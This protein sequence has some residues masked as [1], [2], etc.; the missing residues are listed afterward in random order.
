VDPDRAGV[1]TKVRVYDAE[2][3]TYLGTKQRRS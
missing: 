3:G 2:R 1:I